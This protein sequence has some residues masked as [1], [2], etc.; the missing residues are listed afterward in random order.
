M[1]GWNALQKLNFVRGHAYK[2]VFQT[3]YGQKVLADLRR[4]CYADQPTA[5]PDNEK[6]TY[7][8]EGRR[9]VWLRITAYIGLTQEQINGLVEN[10]NG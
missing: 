4:F 6:V 10:Y 8:R 7:I 2:M 5:D 3:E 1:D 9:E